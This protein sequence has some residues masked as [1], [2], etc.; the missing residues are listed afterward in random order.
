MPDEDASVLSRLRLKAISGRI[1]EQN[2]KKDDF[3]KKK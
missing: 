2:T 3:G 1:V